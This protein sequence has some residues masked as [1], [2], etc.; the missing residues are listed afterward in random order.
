MEDVA[1][2]STTV[3]RFRNIL[4]E[5]ELY[6]RVLGEINRQ[7]EEK[8]GDHQVGCHRRCEYHEHA[9]SPRGR[10]TYGVVEDRD[11]NTNKEVSEKGMIKEIVK[12]NVDSETSLD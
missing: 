11:E 1:P 5:A 9:P 3:C 12:P 10:K 7:L 8:R 6:D 4:V 2:D